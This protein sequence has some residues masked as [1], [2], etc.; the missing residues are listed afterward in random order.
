MIYDKTSDRKPT[1]WAWKLLSG[2]YRENSTP[3]TTNLVKTQLNLIIIVTGVAAVF[4]LLPV[5]R[6]S[7]FDIGPFASQYA[8]LYEGGDATTQG[9]VSITNVTVNGNIGV[10]NINYGSTGK[11]VTFSG[12]GTINGR[13][14]FYAAERNPSQFQNT[15]GGN[16]GP[17]SVNYNVA[18]VNNAL[19][20]VNSLSTTVGAFSGTNKTISDG[21][22]INASAG[23][24]HGDN[25]VFNITSLSL[26]D[27]STVTINGDGIHDV[28]LNFAFD[29]NVN[30]KG[31]I[32]LNGL[33]PDQV[34]WNFTSSGKNI[35]LGKTTTGA[36]QGIIL[37][38]NDKLSAT[39]ATLNGR[40]FG[41]DSQDFSIVSGT[42]I[43]A[44]VPDGGSAVALLGIALAGIEGARRLLRQ[45]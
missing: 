35:D 44:Q 28:V 45:K 22:I 21:T 9:N 41:G 6:A 17:T 19:N 38:P 15:N 14:D 39:N 32:I 8:V 2:C 4:G 24:F 42:T 34:L 27:Q 40:F 3:T 5:Q 1:P 11:K 7:A 37:A 16:V 36:F 18:A 31:Q 26:T 43:T 29:S 13:V 23:T 25:S 20:D 33:T 30:L 12:P 10:G